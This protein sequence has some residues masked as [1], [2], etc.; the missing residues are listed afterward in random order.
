MEIREAI[1]MFCHK[2]RLLYHGKV[3]LKCWKY[4]FR[5]SKSLLDRCTPKNN[6]W[7]ITF[8]TKPPCQRPRFPRGLISQFIQ[9]GNWKKWEKKYAVSRRAKMHVQRG[10]GLFQR[11]QLHRLFCIPEG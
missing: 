2:G 10:S 11:G 4:C 9:T 8:N 5:D 1:Y 7:A 6:Q 3:P